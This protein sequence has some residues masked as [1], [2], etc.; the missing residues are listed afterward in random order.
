MV[1][2]SIGVRPS[3]IVA[4]AL[5]LLL[6]GTP[7]AALLWATAVPGRSHKGPL[8]A[9]SAEQRLLAERLTAHVTAIGTTPHNV[10]HPEALDRAAGY[11]ERHLAGL[12][13]A[14]HRQRF[15][16]DLPIVRNIEVVVAP[17]TTSAPTLVIGAHYDSAGD[18][19][20]AND[21]GSGTAAVIELARRLRA[22]DGRSALRIRLVLFANEEPPFFETEGMGSVAYARRL[23]RSGEPVI[24]MMSLETMGYYSDRPGSQHYPPP[25]SLLYPGTGNFI[26]FVGTTDSRDF[27]RHAVG[28]FRAT[29]PFPS[30]GGTA[31]AF[32]R[33]IDW[34]DHRSFAAVGIPALMVTDTAPFRYP[35]Y[36]A[37]ADTPDKLDYGRL[38]RV[39]EG[40]ERVVRASEKEAR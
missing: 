22:L 1:L 18:A 5:I 6:F 28:T 38:A 19:P 13:Y 24:G 36:H 23:K 34:S 37:Q 39:T 17:R 21:N 2:R 7:V 31:P 4:M 16:P 14:V 8:P 20:G 12:G 32:V 29:T 27:V 33:G 30:V 10:G 40:L 15:Q 3:R 11:I 9:I 35:Y 25:L 26:A